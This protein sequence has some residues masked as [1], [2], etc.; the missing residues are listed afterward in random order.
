M[1]G[2]GS[3]PGERRGGRTKGIPNKKTQEK[4]A[5][6]ENSGLTPLDFLLS[7]MRDGEQELNTRVD[8]GKA[9]AP[10]VHPKLANIELTGK[11]KGPVQVNI[12]RFS[13]STQPVDTSS[14]SNAGVDG[15]R[16]GLPPSSP[17]LAQKKW[18]G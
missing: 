15:A 7:V 14:V 8:A 2:K 12:V 17:M 3:A 9:A 6:I 5:A 10:Y 1:A 16:T 11:D 13:D 4:I 18:Q